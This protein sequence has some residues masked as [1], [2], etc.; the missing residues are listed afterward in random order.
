[1]TVSTIRECE[2]ITVSSITMALPIQVKGSIST[3]EPMLV[4]GRM[5]Q[6]GLIVQSFPITTG[7]V[8]TVWGPIVVPFP[9]RTA[10]R[11]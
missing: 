4:L 9:I 3:R 11:K 8:I 5:Q 6:F 1:M 10:A 7:P 2:P